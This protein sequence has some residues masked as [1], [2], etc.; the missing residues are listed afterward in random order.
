[1][2]IDKVYLVGFMGAGKST[3]ARRL[4]ARLDW[5]AEDIDQRVE[6]RD[7]RTVSAIFAAQ[8]EP[9]FRDLE[10]AAVARALAEHDGVLALG[11][12]AVMHPGTR[13]LLVAHGAGGGVVVWLD[14]DLPSAAKR[15]EPGTFTATRPVARISSTSNLPVSKQYSP[16]TSTP[17]TPP[18][19]RPTRTT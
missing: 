5:R 17:V 14:V 3:L 1:M 9:Y 12:G 7:G 18:L 6:A 19:P 2:P 10:Q 15:V 8:G 13:Q 16:S 11:G 4:A